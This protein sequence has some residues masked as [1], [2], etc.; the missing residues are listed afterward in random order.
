MWSILSQPDGGCAFVGDG[1]TGC[2][3]S[4]CVHGGGCAG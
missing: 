3:S 1:G 4:G 2:I